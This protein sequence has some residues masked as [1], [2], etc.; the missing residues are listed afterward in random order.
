MSSVDKA[1]ILW[2]VA[3]TAIGVG[4]AFGSMIINDVPPKIVETEGDQQSAFW[5]GGVVQQNI[6]PEDFDIAES[7]VKNDD[8]LLDD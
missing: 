4:I 3:I 6:D 1:A 2:S 8:D 5:V 7:S